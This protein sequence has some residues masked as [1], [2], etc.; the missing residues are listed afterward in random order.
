MLISS[1]PFICLLNRPVLTNI[2]VIKLVPR[3]TRLSLESMTSHKHEKHMVA[4][5]LQ[6]SLLFSKQYVLA[7]NSKWNN[8]V[9][10]SA[11]FHRSK[12]A[13]CERDQSLWLQTIVSTTNYVQTYLADTATPLDNNW[14]R[15][16]WVQRRQHNP[17]KSLLS[18]G[19]KTFCFLCLWTDYP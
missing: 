11:S 6:Q 4:Q 19:L 5:T 13:V 1:A 14:H 2:K 12:G 17:W 8:S 7:V 15:L 3:A 18:A 10:Q 9:P 16:W